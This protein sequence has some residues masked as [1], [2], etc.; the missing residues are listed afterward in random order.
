[1][2][3]LFHDDDERSYRTSISTRS[4]GSQRTRRSRSTSPMTIFAWRHC[5][6]TRTTS[7]FVIPSIPLSMRGNILSDRQCT[8]SRI[9]HRVSGGREKHRQGRRQ[10]QRRFRARGV[11]AGAPGEGLH[12]GGSQTTISRAA[13]GE[14]GSATTPG[15]GGS[16]G[17]PGEGEGRRVGGFVLPVRDC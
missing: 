10:R 3:S 12:W 8:G 6:A 15:E 14:G 16:A 9:E 4:S 7:I 11:S 2:T 1:M 17:A 5:R 13:P